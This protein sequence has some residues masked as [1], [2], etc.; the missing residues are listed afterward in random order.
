M[1]EKLSPA[2]R[3]VPLK[4][5]ASDMAEAARLSA[6]H[7]P[8]AWLRFRMYVTASEPQCRAQHASPP[9]KDCE[10][11]AQRATAGWRLHLHVGGPKGRVQD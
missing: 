7:R 3:D 11:R 2:V 10:S 5:D 9:V 4:R 8:M 6:M 1:T